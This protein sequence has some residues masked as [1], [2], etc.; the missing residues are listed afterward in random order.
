MKHDSYL[1]L[2]MS[3]AHYSRMLSRAH[4]SEAGTR[5]ICSEHK[6]G[7]G[8]I[9]PAIVAERVCTPHTVRL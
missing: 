3:Q 2:R 6:F 1:R 8:C 9:S 5:L 7:I 4:P